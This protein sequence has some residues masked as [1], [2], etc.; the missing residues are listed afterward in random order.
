M[1][2]RTTG[3]IFNIIVDGY[4][5]RVKGGK[6]DRCSVTICRYDNDDVEDHGWTSRGYP[7]KYPITVAS[8]SV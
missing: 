2:T 7:H 5:E 3:R 1:T 4:I 6:L 8:A